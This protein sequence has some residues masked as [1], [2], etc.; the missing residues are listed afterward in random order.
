MP[1]NIQADIDAHLD[2]ASRLIGKADRI[3]AN[4]DR[5][6]EPENKA[7]V[8]ALATLALAHIALVSR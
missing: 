6:D 5:F 4:P 1:R 7:E 2:A 3:E 8:Q